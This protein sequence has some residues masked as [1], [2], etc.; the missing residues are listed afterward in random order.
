MHRNALNVRKV[1]G[2]RLEA[3]RREMGRG[4]EIW[5]R[6]LANDARFR[7][8]KSPGLGEGRRWS[9]P[10]WRRTLLGPLLAD[11]PLTL[12]GAE[13]QPVSWRAGPSC[14]PPGTPRPFPTALPP[15]PAAALGLF[16]QVS[17]LRIK[18]WFL[19][20]F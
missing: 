17:K 5:G 1:A 7:E 10:P 14:D 6:M 3:R 11:L 16:F 18:C 15:S 20:C 13:R 19:S 4:W 2:E 8:G 12:G 9:L